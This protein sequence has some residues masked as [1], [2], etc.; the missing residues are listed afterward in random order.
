MKNLLK[1]LILFCFIAPLVHAEDI[2]NDGMEDGWERLYGLVVGEDDSY[3]DLDCDGNSNLKEFLTCTNPANP[4]DLFTVKSFEPDN[5]GS[6]IIH[7]SVKPPYK[8][9]VEYSDDLINWFILE[10]AIVPSEQDYFTID[11][12]S[13]K[14][15]APFSESVINRYYR[16]RFVRETEIP[17]EHEIDEGSFVND[18]TVTLV[19]DVTAD[20]MIISENPDFRDCAWITFQ[21]TYEYTL[22]DGD[23]EKILYIKFKNDDGES[24]VKS[25]SVIYD[26]VP[27]EIEV[28]SP[29]GILRKVIKGKL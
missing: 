10:D 25:E 21:F 18:N 24:E 2:D 6:S 9:C 3:L 26:T 1:I 27:P 4:E 8:Y 5:D 14:R 13:D 28:E 19:F 15:E 16:A 22:S 23:G 29:F 17:S 11:S 20:M 7:I 12:G